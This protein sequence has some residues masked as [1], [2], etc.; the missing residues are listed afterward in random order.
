MGIE[1]GLPGKKRFDDL[2]GSYFS[3]AHEARKLDR[4]KSANIVEC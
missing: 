4:A 1:F 3:L 2:D